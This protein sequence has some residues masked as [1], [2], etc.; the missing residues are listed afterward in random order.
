[1]LYIYKKN[2]NLFKVVWDAKVKA[3]EYKDNYKNI[4]VE[5]DEKYPNSVEDIIQYQEEYH[6]KSKP[7][8]EDFIKQVKQTNSYSELKDRMKNFVSVLSK[9]RRGLQFNN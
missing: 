3:S 4:L 2:V 5:L 6:R 7:I 1:M 8:E 9:T